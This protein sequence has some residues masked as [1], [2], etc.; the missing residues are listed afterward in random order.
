MAAPTNS[1]SIRNL[2]KQTAALLKSVELLWELEKRN[3]DR[4][5]SLSSQMVEASVQTLSRIAVLE[6][7]VAELK[8]QSEERDRK[9]WMIG[10]ALGGSV[11]TFVANL[12][13]LL[14]RK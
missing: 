10:M 13:L 4:L 9:F 3:H 11:L 8:R 14:L 6:H 2:E 1:E 5:E 7:Q 12:V